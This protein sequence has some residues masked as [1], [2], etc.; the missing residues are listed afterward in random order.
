MVREAEPCRGTSETHVYDPEVLGEDP[1]PEGLLR[2]GGVDPT[3]LTHELFYALNI[4]GILLSLL[5]LLGLL[6][7]L[8]WLLR[9]SLGGGGSCWRGN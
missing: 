9:R 7:L 5:T 2:G 1:L 3:K 8:D 4:I 6:G